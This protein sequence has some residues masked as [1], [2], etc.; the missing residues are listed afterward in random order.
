MPTKYTFGQTIPDVERILQYHI[1]T[2]GPNS[3]CDQDILLRGNHTYS[4]RNNKYCS[5]CR[6]C[7]CDEL[8]VFLA[9]CCLDLQLNMTNHFVGS[10]KIREEDIVCKSEV[11][12]KRRR[13]SLLLTRNVDKYPVLIKCPND[14]TDMDIIRKCENPDLTN[15]L[16]IVPVTST[17]TGLTYS[18]MG[19]FTCHGAKYPVMWNMRLQ[20]R[21]QRR[22]TE[23]AIVSSAEE[24]LQMADEKNCKLIYEPN[25]DADVLRTCYNPPKRMQTCR[26]TDSR[27]DPNIIWGCENVKFQIDQYANMFCSLCNDV[28]RR[29]IYHACNKTGKWQNFDNSLNERCINGSIAWMPS[30]IKPYRNVDC[31]L[32]N[33]QHNTGKQCHVMA[34]HRASIGMLFDMAY[35]LGSIHIGEVKSDQKCSRRK[36]FDAYQVISF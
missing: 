12:I 16:S 11:N 32:C 22:P 3:L 34:N 20:C 21:K 27:I 25:T 18:N 5:P 6:P 2:C 28:V 1:S 7:F 14:T 26:E 35:L 4:D 31:Y 24:I 19:C 33:L 8:C 29:P 23:L 9:D 15:L 17:E 30:G 10:T 36:V 13:R